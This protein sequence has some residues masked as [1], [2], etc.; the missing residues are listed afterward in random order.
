MLGSG[1]ETVGKGPAPQARAEERSQARELEQDLG[2]RRSGSKTVP[3]S[4]HPA[5]SPAHLAAGTN[6]GDWAAGVA[7]EAF[8]RPARPAD[9]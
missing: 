8:T 3:T 5:G 1:P 2:S 6:T 7:M 9:W 4:P